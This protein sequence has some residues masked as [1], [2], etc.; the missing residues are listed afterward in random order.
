M[1]TSIDVYNNSQTFVVVHGLRSIETAKEFLALFPKKL[2][3]KI[4]RPFFGISSNNYRTLQIH[5][6]L[7]TYIANK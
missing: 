4:E 2:K 7:Q 5:K 1:S 3:E 6:N